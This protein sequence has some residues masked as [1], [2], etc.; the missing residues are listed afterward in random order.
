[1]LWDYEEVVKIKISELLKKKIRVSEY[2]PQYIFSCGVFFSFIFFYKYV[3]KCTQELSYLHTVG[4]NMFNKCVL[5]EIKHL[6]CID[7]K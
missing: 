1:M 3:L 7:L 2:T 6:T 4:F 5:R